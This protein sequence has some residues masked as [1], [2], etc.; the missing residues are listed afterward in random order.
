[1]ENPQ[2]EMGYTGYSPWLWKAPGV[3][4]GQL[5][6]LAAARVDIDLHGAGA[7]NATRK[8]PDALHGVLHH[9]L[10]TAVRRMGKRSE[11]NQSPRA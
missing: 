4:A 7:L 2:N 8:F 1:M 10:A 5:R 9:G 3:V 11:G 6:Y